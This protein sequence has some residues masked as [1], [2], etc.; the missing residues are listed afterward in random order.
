MKWVFFIV[1]LNP[2]LSAATTHLVGT[3]SGSVS[4][5]SM[6]GF[7]QGDTLLIKTGTYTG[8]TFDNLLH[9]T[10][11]PQVGMSYFTGQV[12]FRYNS[13]V[14]WGY[15][16]WSGYTGYALDA[17]S[18][19][20][21]N[22]NNCLL[23]NMTFLNLNSNIILAHGNFYYTSGDTSTYA[24]YKVT[25]DSLYAYGC[26]ELVE[27]SFGTP[28]DNSGVPPDVF[29]LTTITR[30][31]NEATSATSE[32][33]TQVRGIMYQCNFHDW[34]ITSTTQR[35]ASGD[36]GLIYGYVSGKFYNIYKW[37]GPGYII[38]A[39]P[40]AEV[41]HPDSINIYNCA[42]IFSTDYGLATV[43]FAAADT[44]AG[45]TTNVL[46]VNIYNNTLINA[47]TSITYWCQV[48]VLGTRGTARYQV[49]NNVGANIMTTGKPDKIVY[50]Q[51]ESWPT[52]SSD[53]SNNQ[54]YSY[55]ALGNLDS[56]STTIVNS[57]GSFG[58]YSPTPS[59]VDLV[60][61]GI[62]NSMD[63]I[64]YFGIGRPNPPSLGYAEIQNVV[65][66]C[67]CSAGYRGAMRIFIK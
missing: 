3:G 54:Y 30:Y 11:R 29:C 52:E 27:G 60:G 64:D 65:G 25:L 23:H 7:S 10:I 47:A 2:L 36:V 38:R 9:I 5:T 35:N 31:K 1:F 48:A 20:G 24:W 49:R 18:F 53:T 13:F 42:K 26:G 37:G 45:K 58:K 8:G 34:A 6:S 46:A 67:N 41:S 28:S 33:G 4:V 62:H 50:N 39:F 22:V 19:T 44:F 55:A 51:G 17:R 40:T 61:K 57:L 66:N 56:V 63:L 21:L 32:E 14:D 16:T 12:E 59:S 43:Q 15:V